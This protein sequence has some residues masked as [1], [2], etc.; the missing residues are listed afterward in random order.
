MVKLLAL[1]TRGRN[2]TTEL[3]CASQLSMDH[4]VRVL[5]IPYCLIQVKDAYLQFMLHCYIDAD[6]EMKD[7][8]NVDFIERI[9][10]NIFSDIQMYIASL[11]QICTSK[12]LNQVLKVANM[13]ENL[14]FERR[15]ISNF[16]KWLLLNLILYPVSTM[17]MEKL[18]LLPNSAFEKYVCYTATEV[19]VKLFERPSAYQ[20][21]VE[22]SQQ[23]Q[24][25]SRM[26]QSLCRLQEELVRKCFT[27]NWYRVAECVRRLSRRAEENGVILSINGYMQPGYTEATVK[28]R[29]QSAFNSARFI[30][31]TNKCAKTRLHVPRYVQV[32]ESFS[33][34]VSCYQAMVNEFKVF[35]LPLQTAETSVLVDVLHAPER[36]FISGSDLYQKCEN[37]VV[38]AKLIQHCKSLLQHGQEALC[39]RVL[40]TLCQM[41]SNTKYNFINQ[42]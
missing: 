41:A 40:Q 20:L 34:V 3:K 23:H 33:S 42:V 14:K 29:W 8:D 28:Q 5:T 36:L 12:I 11:S 1:C 35:A 10:K 17:K 37:G 4:I 21:I 2:S 26:I 38:I 22:I 16:M 9:M 7:V 31:Q 27:K 18:T 32:A 24:F 6:A 25:F 39:V 19:L 15:L 30:N 13:K